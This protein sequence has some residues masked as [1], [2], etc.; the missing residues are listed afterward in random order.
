MYGT[1]HQVNIL[2]GFAG[3]LVLLLK[4][5]ITVWPN[6]GGI[7][8]IRRLIPPSRLGWTKTF[9]LIKKKS[10]VD[11]FKIIG[12]SVLTVKAQR[13]KSRQILIFLIT[14]LQ[15]LCKTRLFKSILF[16]LIEFLRT[17]FI[18][19]KNNHIIFIII[20]F[21][22]GCDRPSELFFRARFISFLNPLFLSLIPL[23]SFFAFFCILFHSC[24]SH[25][26]VF[27]KIL[28]PEFLTSYSHTEW[29]LLF[30]ESVT[31]SLL[32]EFGAKK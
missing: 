21:W 2:L 32:F 3:T 9:D 18:S 6:C 28:V 5:S 19:Y 31:T 14:C 11:K 30:S 4:F 24:C 7:S 22:L 29:Y 23:L 12:W 15:Q 25:A 27:G 1:T 26:Q 17:F 16:L 20:V 8:E 13:Q 10:K